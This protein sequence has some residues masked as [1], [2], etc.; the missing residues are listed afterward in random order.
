M[1]RGRLRSSLAL[2]ALAAALLVPASAGAATTLGETSSSPVNCGGGQPYAVA[3]DATAAGAPSY[4][5]P[6]DGVLT[7]WSHDARGTGPQTGRLKVFRPTGNAGELFA[8]GQSAV[9][10]L[11]LGQLNTFATRIEVKAGDRLGFTSVSGFAGCLFLTGEDDD[12][13]YEMPANDLQPG[14][15]QGDIATTKR[16]RANVTAVLEPDA[17]GDGYGDESQD[18]CAGVAN[19]GQEDGDGDGQGNACDFD[20]DNDLVL[21]QADNC[22]LTS[23]GDQANLDNDGQGDACDPDDDDDARPDGQDNC[24]RVTNPDQ[25][26]GDGDGVG[27]ACDDRDDGRAAT[28]SARTVAKQKLATVLRKGARFDLRCDEPCRLFVQLVLDGRS[29]KKLRLS[30]PGLA[31]VLGF[32]NNLPAEANRTVRVTVKLNRRARRALRRARSLKAKLY[33]VAQDAARNTAAPRA[34]SVRLK[35]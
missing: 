8:V 22:P 4:T 33:V 10:N 30:K 7:S 23:N 28:V 1:T 9:E 15:T 32:R 20:A 24:P 11:T 25:L 2:V 21:D 31:Y 29:A 6:S 3:Q 35:R 16:G 12:V 34:Y 27:A 26:D 17:D 14:S 5:V 13:L 19:A 18:N